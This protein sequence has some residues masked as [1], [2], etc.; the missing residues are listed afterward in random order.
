MA[1]ISDER[2]RNAA[3]FGA[4]YQAAR[5]RAGQ[6]PSALPP[7][8]RPFGVDRAAAY[9]RGVDLQNDEW[10]RRAYRSSL[11]ELSTAGCTD[12]AAALMAAWRNQFNGRDGRSDDYGWDHEAVT[13]CL[14]QMGSRPLPEP[15]KPIIEFNADSWITKVTVEFTAPVASREEAIRLVKFAFPSNWSKASNSFFKASELG[16]FVG[17]VFQPFKSD[18][19]L[20]RDW[21]E[22]LFLHEN[23]RWAWNGDSDFETDNHF[24]IRVFDFADEAGPSKEDEE[25]ETILEYSYSLSS[26]NWSKSVVVWDAGGLD[27]DQGSYRA[28]FRA[29]KLKIVAVKS[30]RFVA[31][32]NGPYEIAVALNL[33]APATI[34]MLLSRLNDFA[35]LHDHLTDSKQEILPWPNRMT[36]N[37]ISSRHPTSQD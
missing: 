19:D 23:V 37:R 15:T 3:L 35:A 1:T 10:V 9:F 29:G 11:W 22:P 25:E 14:Q 28:T 2:H 30:V 12:Q 5:R 6:A 8:M 18:A 26:C 13:R 16:T 17:S 27:V 32:R 4:F 20:C 31:P 33:M 21:N 24:M 7:E 34:S 36:T